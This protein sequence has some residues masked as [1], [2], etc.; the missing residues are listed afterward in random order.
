MCEC[1]YYAT[2][3]EGTSY[4]GQ[5]GML[6][7]TWVIFE[8]IFCT[9]SAR[10]VPFFNKISAFFS[11]RWVSILKKISVFVEQ[12]GT[13]LQEIFCISFHKVAAFHT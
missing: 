9:F 13:H 7:Y 4:V 10:W 11:A 3:G 6:G 5:Y 2:P 1:K 12:D 8:K